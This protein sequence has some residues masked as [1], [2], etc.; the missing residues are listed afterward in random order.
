MLTSFSQELLVDMPGVP[1]V[2]EVEDNPFLATGSDVLSDD[3]EEVPI[4][5]QSGNREDLRCTWN[6][7]PRNVSR[8]RKQMP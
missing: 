6:C 1:D 4:F 7:K 2:I 3:R 8:I 5:L